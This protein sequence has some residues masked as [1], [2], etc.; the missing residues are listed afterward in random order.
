[1]VGVDVPDWGVPVLLAGVV[2][3][4]GCVPAGVVAGVAG[5]ANASGVLGGN[6]LAV[7]P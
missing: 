1:M 6:G 3:P 4:A 2:P 7:M 5:G